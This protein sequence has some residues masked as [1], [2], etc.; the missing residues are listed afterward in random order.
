MIR[1]EDMRESDVEACIDI[2]LEAFTPAE[3][4]I[5]KEDPRAVRARHFREELART[6]ARLRVAR[7]EDGVVV[8]Y[9]LSWHVADEAQLLNVAVGVSSRRKGI[10]RLLVEDLVAHARKTSAA[11]VLLEVRASNVAAIAM[12]EALSFERFNLRAGYYADGEDAVEMWR[13][14]G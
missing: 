2:D 4:A 10:G 6:W 1:I 11:R 14:L 12:Y 8:G 9:T 7:S 3:M 13:E 5:G